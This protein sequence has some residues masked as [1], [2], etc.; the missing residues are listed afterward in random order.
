MK[1]NGKTNCVYVGTKVGM[2]IFI[3]MVLIISILP[4]LNADVDNINN[5]SIYYEEDANKFVSEDNLVYVLIVGIPIPIED[6]EVLGGGELSSDF[7]ELALSTEEGYNPIGYVKSDIITPTKF[8]GWE[9]I[10]WKSS[11]ATGDSNVKIQVLD[12]NG[13]LIE[14]LDGNSN[15]FANSP[16]DLSSLGSSY[17]SIILQ[18]ILSSE[19]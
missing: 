8:Y 17:P 11:E 15:G 3:C 2:T 16:I 6:I 12:I 14:S 4:I 7:L 10:I 19:K 1:T 18:A 5:D 13:D 9:N